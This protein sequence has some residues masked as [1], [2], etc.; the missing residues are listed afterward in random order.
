[1]ADA[2]PALPQGIG[3]FRRL[4]PLAPVGYDA[5]RCLHARKPWVECTRCRDACPA[6][7]LVLVDRSLSIDGSA[8][9]GCGRCTSACPTQALVAEGFDLR[10][11]LP[12]ATIGCARQADLSPDAIR[13]PCL[14]GLHINDLLALLERMPEGAVR[15]AG[16]TPCTDCPGGAKDAAPGRRLVAEI[17]PVL[18]S[19]SVPADRLAARSIPSSL[20]DGN[21]RSRSAA[22]NRPAGPTASRRAFFSGLGRAVSDRI[23]RKAAEAQTLRLPATPGDPGG[24]REPIATVRAL[25]T[26]LYMKAL[27][28]RSGTLPDTI[29]LPRITASD[30]CCLHGGC[31][32]LCPTGALRIADRGAVRELRFDAAQCIDCGACVRAC[33]ERALTIEPP[34]WRDF[35]EGDAVLAR[36]AI[37]GCTR[38]GEPVPARSTEGLCDH[39]SKSA[40][41]ARAGFALFSRGA[42][43]PP[44]ETGPP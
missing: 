16:D 40:G 13:L 4:S 42:C 33:P 8:C 36:A 17:E 27:A 29:V 21:S 15:L 5:T 25:D 3:R 1:M 14:G 38:C 39:C 37:A 20:P 22:P 24:P 34:A 30:A 26:R 28:A 11:G 12:V 9:L 35:S 19:S 41:L 23:V 31:T 43:H 2:H 6:D 44:A 18:R 7:C 32:R 10:P